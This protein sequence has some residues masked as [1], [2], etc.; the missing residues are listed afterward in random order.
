[1]SSDV[2]DVTCNDCVCQQPMCVWSL[3]PDWWSYLVY[4]GRLAVSFLYGQYCLFYCVFANSIP[5]VQLYIVHSNWLWTSS[6]Y[7]CQRSTCRNTQIG[8]I[9]QIVCVVDYQ[10]S[11]T[12]YRHGV[13]WIFVRVYWEMRLTVAIVLLGCAKLSLSAC[14]SHWSWSVWLV[15]RDGGHGQSQLYPFEEGSRVCADYSE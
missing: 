15:S 6:W 8:W 13:T 12:D 7:R 4:H 2:P 1:M 9:V 14:S 10:L 5:I 3:L 11:L